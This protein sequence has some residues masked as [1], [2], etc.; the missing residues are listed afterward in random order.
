MVIVL[1]ALNEMLPYVLAVSTL[2]PIVVA[3]V[4]RPQRG[5]L[6]LAAL[7]PLD[8]LLPLVTTSR[9]VPYWKE[10]LVVAVARRVKRSPAFERSSGL[11]PLPHFSL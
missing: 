3:L 5:V 4:K 2:I 9:V 7:A 6:V 11:K 10:G 1:A 8:G